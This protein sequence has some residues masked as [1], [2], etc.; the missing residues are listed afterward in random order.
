[1]KIRLSV[2]PPDDLTDITRL[3]DDLRN[4]VN[5]GD[6]DGVDGATE[7]LLV[8]TANTRSVNLSEEE[9][10]RFLAGAKVQNAAFQSN[11]LISE[12]LCSQ[13][14]PDAPAETMILQL[15]FN[16]WEDEDV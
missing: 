3:V 10:R 2:I 4:A 13:Y 12:E 7:K 14:F 6:M 8:L 11:Y 16:E 5:A 15:P 1:M 9:W